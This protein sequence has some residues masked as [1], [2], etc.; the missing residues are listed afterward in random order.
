ME[1]HRIIEIDGHK[2][3]YRDEGRDNKHTVVFLHGFM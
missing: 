2:V 1:Q 3:H